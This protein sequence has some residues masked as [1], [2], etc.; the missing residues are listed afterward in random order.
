MIDTLEMRSWARPRSERNQKKHAGVVIPSSGTSFN[1]CKARQVRR[2][3]PMRF[4][5]VIVSETVI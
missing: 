5:V 3:A 2:N 4:L 1:C